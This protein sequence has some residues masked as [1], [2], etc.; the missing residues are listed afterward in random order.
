M[1]KVTKTQSLTQSQRDDLVLWGRLQEKVHV[2]GYNFERACR[3]LE[4]LLEGDRWK[5]GGQFKSVDD[6]MGSIGLDKLRG[7]AEER[8][9]IA[10]RIRELQPKVSNRKIAKAIGVSHQTVGRDA[11]PSGPKRTKKPAVSGPNGP[12]V[13]EFHVSV[14]LRLAQAVQWHWSVESQRARNS[15][16]PL[17]AIMVNHGAEQRSGRRSIAM[18]VAQTR[19]SRYASGNAMCRRGASVGQACRLGGRVCELVRDQKLEVGLM[20]LADPVTPT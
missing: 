9:R 10:N 8:K 18:L 5:L 20:L 17:V 11:G 16:A 14:E 2:A 1:T 6:F 12:P 13:S 4:T 19:R 7:T 15:S 3:D